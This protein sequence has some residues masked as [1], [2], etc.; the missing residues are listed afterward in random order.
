MEFNKKTLRNIFIGV[1]A[2]IVV[3]WGLHE[4]D[5]LGALFAG[6]GK[7]LSPFAVGAA[8]AFIINVPMRPIEKLF[9]KVKSPGARRALAILAT[10]LVV[11]LVITGVVLLVIPQIAETVRSLIEILP[12]FFN[13][14]IETGR[15]FLKDNPQLQQ[16]LN[17]NTDFDS[18]NWTAWIEQIASMLTGGMT[19]VLDGLFTAVID[20]STGIFNAVVSFVFAIYC[21]ARKE[22]LARQGRQILYSVF[23]EKV[24]DEVIRIL[25]M[26]NVTF[27]NFISGQSLE[28]VILG[29]MFAVS[30]TIF[31]MPFMPLVSVIISI[32]ALV[33]IVGAFVGCVLGA[34]FILVQDPVLAFTFVIMFLVLQQIEGNL[35]YP[36]VVGT[37]IGL[38]GMWV[39]LAVA[40]GGDLMGI[41]GMLVMIPLSSVLY[42]LTREFT[43]KRL[44]AKHIPAEKLQAQPP[45]ITS[46]FKESRK[47]KKEEK[48]QKMTAG[49]DNPQNEEA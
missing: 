16:W 14:I 7:V 21:L 18:I 28:A 4:T 5:R 45:E 33:P 36:R 29:A 9:G 30:M 24:S 2:C 6:I 32:T 17:E 42:A 1:I 38:P 43:Q 39:L 8:L 19:K 40:V 37:S 48:I 15:Q 25:R 22:I 27:S 3:Y 11:A 47:K 10:I 34:F 31:R 23:P 46:K 13:R 12:D 49:K 26:T 44:A 35:I 20:F 41:G